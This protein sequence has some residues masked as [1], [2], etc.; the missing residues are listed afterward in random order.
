MSQ[1]ESERR[2][3]EAKARAKAAAALQG[4]E[5][6]DAELETVAAAGDEPTKGSS[7]GGSGSPKKAG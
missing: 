1:S 3:E 2:A 4:R 7:S 6:S 5:L